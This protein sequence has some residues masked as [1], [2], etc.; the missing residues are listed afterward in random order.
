[1]PA[2]SQTQSEIL[3]FLK[4]GEGNFVSGAI[5]AEKLGISRTGIWKHIQK[6]KTMGYD[7]T[8]H[9]KEG[10][11]L[12]EVPDSLALKEIEPHLA[13]EWLGRSY[14]YLEDTESTNDH[15]LLLAAQGFPHGTTV[16]AE[17]QSKGRGRLRRE[18]VSLPQR[19]IYMSILLRTPLPVRMAPQ[20]TSVAAL[21]LVKVLR[22]RFELPASI[23]WP[24]DVLISGKKTAGI[25]TEMQS[26]Q[27]YSRF[28]VIGIGINVNYSEQELAGPFRYPAT[29]VSIEMGAAV[30]RQ[31]LLLEFL[32][33]FEKDY[34][35]FL[36]KGFSNL[37]PQLE[38]LSGILGRT[39]TIVCG[40]RELKG[41]AQG[42]TPEG[43]LMLLQDDGSLETVWVG[44]VVRVEGA[45]QPH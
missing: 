39:V 14:H 36:E 13:T 25:L 23:K 16:V 26:D 42:F 35:E 22:T 28:I 12:V 3:K 34:Q 38:K 5:L 24:N 7:I 8:T 1:M 20:T 15:A 40:D 29:S 17:Q 4:E 21:A 27:D 2:T 44:D 43:A 11:K 10:Y 37:I 31:H 6:L 19:G 45:T 33:Q 32:Q 18:W 9:P 41:K 30:K